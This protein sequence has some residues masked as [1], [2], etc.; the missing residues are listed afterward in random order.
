MNTNEKIQYLSDNYYTQTRNQLASNVGENPRWV[1]K[2]IEL[3]QHQGKIAYKNDPSIL[4]DRKT[5]DKIQYLIDN[6]F[7]GKKK[8][9]AEHLNE[10]PRWVKR[11]ISALIKS[12]KIVPKVER[13]ERVLCEADWTEE[14]KNRA[15]ELRH[16]YL[17]TNKQICQILKEEF[18]LDINP[19]VFQFWMDR[20]GYHGKTKQEWLVEYLPKSLIEDLFEKSY[21]IIDISKYLKDIYGVYVSDDLILVHVQKLD[22][23]SLKLKKINDIKTESEKFSK[24]WLQ[25]KIEGHAGLRGLEEEMGVSKTIVMKRI[26]EEGLHLIKHRKIWSQN[27]ET[28]RDLLLQAKPLDVPS[29][30]FHQMMLGWLIGDGHL[31]INGRFVTNHSLHQLDYL[32]LKM[33]VLKK[34][35]SNVVTVPSHGDEIYRGG[36]EQIGISCPGLGSYLKYLNPDGSKNYE[37]IYSEMDSLG[38]ACYFMDDGSYFGGQVMSINSHFIDSFINRFIFGE[39]KT[40]GNLGVKNIDPQYIIPG[41]AYKCPGQKVG[42]FWKSYV[43]ELFNPSIENCFDLCLVKEGIIKDNPALL[44][45]VV[46]YY[47]QA[48]FPY[49][50]ISNDYLV[51]EF[52]ELNKMDSGLMWN[53]DIFRYVTTGNA[54]FK[55]FMPHMAE[56][57]YR[58]SSPL[59]NFNN[60]S[61]F[62]KVLEYTLKNKKSILPDY[63]YDSLVQLGGVVGFPCLLA[64]GIIERFSNENDVV[65]DPCAGWGGRLLG[66]MSSGRTYVG[67][68]PWGKTVQ[69]L[70]DIMNFYQVNKKNI[71]INS[72]FDPKI[73]PSSCNLIFTSPPYIDLEVYENPIG[74]EGWKS[75]MEKIFR[76]AEEALVP[77]GT[78]VLSL[79]RSLKLMLP[80]T[81]MIEKDPLFWA[82]S[83]RTKSIEKAEPLFIW[84]KE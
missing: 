5:P 31:D 67:F 10:S 2:H 78:M 20:F 41:F 59:G 14:I 22:M 44:N 84:K 45:S 3:L 62:Y 26:K 35:V 70:H 72:D 34:N 6:Y 38:W 19:P 52:D 61:L 83:A 53:E 11:Q 27:L 7:S 24:E 21:R 54:I 46:G 23:L 32:Y 80:Q 69:G 9:L 50:K 28:L 42:D 37:M 57:K 58:N 65:V 25:K 43:P 73:A 4:V 33:R 51:K 68:E 36:G 47:M 1:R 15:K 29:E 55:H 40:N 66:A 18:D 76:Y 81:T 48:G 17:K 30:L 49:F 63:V 56:A 74:T 16:K 79:P 8:D 82:T 60:Y 71:I 77:N 39:K 12:G 75:L 13:P 64:K